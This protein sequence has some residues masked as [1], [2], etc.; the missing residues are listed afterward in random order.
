MPL[1]EKQGA[2]T[3]TYYLEIFR[4]KNASLLW[5]TLE[6]AEISTVNKVNNKAFHMYQT[7][8]KRKA[9]QSL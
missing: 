5:K 8:V 3:I 9:L 2:K 1:C 4:R 6:Y 7:T